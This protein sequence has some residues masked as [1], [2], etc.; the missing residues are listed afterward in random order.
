MYEA[1]IENKNGEVFILTGDE[2]RYQVIDITGLNPAR[3]QINTVSTAGLDGARFNSSKLNTKNIVITIKINGNAEQ[4][5]I[6]LYNY[7]RTK[8]W[9]RFY[10]SNDS[11]DVFIDG[12]VEGVE[13]GLFSRKEIM[14]ISIICPSP[15]FNAM[16]EI[17]TDISNTLKLFVFPFSINE[18]EPIPFSEYTENRITRIFNDCESEIGVVIEITFGDEANAIIIKNTTTG[19]EFELDY[20]F[21]I[22]DVVTIDTNKGQKTVYLMRDGTKINMFP[23]LKSGS[24]FFQLAA[25]INTFGYLAD[26][27][28]NKDIRIVFTYRN[29]YRGV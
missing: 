3:A 28:E 13:C 17:I 2:P 29:Q 5:R 24:V 9:C 18:G 20:A 22:G 16:S 14:Q 6:N 19:E 12:Y 21:E 23:A 15:Y 26:G 1:N 25:G 8:E 27:E 4:N 7:F 11:R 10:Y